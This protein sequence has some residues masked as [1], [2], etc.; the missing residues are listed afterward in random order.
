MK[1][2]NPQ[3][4]YRHLWMI[5]SSL[6]H[7]LCSDVS[8]SHDEDDHT[9]FDDI[10]HTIEASRTA[11]NNDTSDRSADDIALGRPDASSGR[12]AVKDESQNVQSRKK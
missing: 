3:T 5:P 7:N 12:Q 8:H 6:C 11:L 4:K 1:N 10:T 9:K 2:N